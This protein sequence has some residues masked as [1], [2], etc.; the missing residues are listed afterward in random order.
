V[1]WAATAFAPGPER[2]PWASRYLY[3]DAVLFLL[4]L[5]ELGRGLDVP[6]RLTRLGWAVVAVAF[7]ISIAGNIR[8]LRNQ[9]SILVEDSHYIRAGLTALEMSRGTVAPTFQLD[10]TLATATP[11]RTG[12]L[13]NS[14]VDNGVPIRDVQAGGLFRVFD[15]YGS[16]AFT[17]AEITQQSPG[18]R[19]AA[20][21]VLVRAMAVRLVPTAGGPSDATRPAPRPIAPPG[22]S[23]S[24]GSQGC[25]KL[26]RSAGAGTG[27]VALGTQGATVHAGD[28]GAVTVNV[29]RFGDG[30]PVH[31]GTV[32]AGASAELRIPPDFTPEQSPIRWRV[33][34]E[35]AAGAS[36]CGLGPPVIG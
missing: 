19:R 35:D 29:G 13:G 7:A 16:P 25:V 21:V 18:V 24:A 33:G 11:E 5:C 9:T 36:V 34:V 12:P 10:S 28:G 26:S 30:T 22:D 27:M 14:L 1:F 3:L 4:L 31:L 23:W 8:E 17:P 6:R 32:P 15:R 20:D 2:V